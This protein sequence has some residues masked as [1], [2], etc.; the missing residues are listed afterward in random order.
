MTRTTLTRRQAMTAAAGAALAATGHS[1]TSAAPAAPD[2]GPIPADHDYEFT[3]YVELTIGHWLPHAP[4]A[5]GGTVTA[6]TYQDADAKYLLTGGREGGAWHLRLV[7]I[8]VEDRVHGIDIEAPAVIDLNGQTAG[9]EPLAL[10]QAALGGQLPTPGNRCIYDLTER[11]FAAL[12]AL[13]EHA[14]AGIIA[15]LQ[16]SDGEAY[17]PTRAMLRSWGQAFA[18]EARARGLIDA[19]A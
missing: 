18:P 3:A 15:A 14:Q 10:L 8:L 9:T 13:P 4:N 6:G 17:R 1:P 7:P 19:D 16:D 12:T 2:L 5:G 11:E